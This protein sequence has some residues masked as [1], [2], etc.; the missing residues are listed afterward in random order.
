MSKIIIDNRTT[1][2]DYFVLQLVSSVVHRGRVSNDGKQY[3]YAVQ[4]PECDVF[5][6]LNEKSD[7]FIVLPKHALDTERKTE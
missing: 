5:S 6:G 2:P 3:C 7:R 4:F 1:L